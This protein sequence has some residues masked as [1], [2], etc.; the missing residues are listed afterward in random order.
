LGGLNLWRVSISP[1]SFATLAAIRRAF[2]EM[3]MAFIGYENLAVS[4]LTPEIHA[5]PKNEN[6][7]EGRY[8]H[9]F[10]FVHRG[11]VESHD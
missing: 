5:E 2:G 9:Q 11:D 8:D 1:A 3:W 10:D 4:Y 6:A 7:K